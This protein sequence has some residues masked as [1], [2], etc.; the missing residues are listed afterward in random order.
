MLIIMSP[1]TC[2]RLGNR[3]GA[4]LPR[5]LLLPLAAGTAAELEA[6]S[7]VHPDWLAPPTSCPHGAHYSTAWWWEGGRRSWKPAGAAG[8][9]GQSSSQPALRRSA[10]GQLSPSFLNKTKTLPPSFLFLLLCPRYYGDR[11]EKWNY[12]PS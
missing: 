7:G 6:P 2:G 8:V 9:G 1:L 11:K 5:S 12:G 4:F 3:R 10:P